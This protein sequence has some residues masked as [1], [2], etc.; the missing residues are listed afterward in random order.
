[1]NTRHSS[2]APIAG[3]RILL[4]VDRRELATI[5]AAL[6]FHQDENLQGTEQIADQVVG[7]IATDGETLI[8]LN[9]GEVGRL[10][11]RLNC[12]AQPAGLNIEPPHKESIGAES[13]FRVVYVIDVNAATPCEAAEQVHQIMTDP[14]SMAPSLEIIDHTGATVTVDLS[15]M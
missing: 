14:E 9:H 8:P 3:D 2:P 12:E 11:Q 6:R 1:M 10:C 5:L 13:L 15:A 4:R 7:D